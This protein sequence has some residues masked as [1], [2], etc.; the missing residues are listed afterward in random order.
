[1]ASDN[2][3]RWDRQQ[4]TRDEAQ[5]VIE[6]FFGEALK[7]CAWHAD[8]FFVT[9]IGQSSHPLMRVV[10]DEIKTKLEVQ[11]P[12][13][14]DWQGRFLEV[15]LGDKSLDV[16]TRHQDTFTN[17]CARGL[18]AVFAQRWKGRLEE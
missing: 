6:D 15:W 4:P 5:K 13:E 11:R 8:R 1:M 9:L 2:F 14:P 7:E 16:L 3:V 18:A 10:A 12:T 17:V